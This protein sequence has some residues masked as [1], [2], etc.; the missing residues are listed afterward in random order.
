[1]STFTVDLQGA[2]RAERIEGVRS[3]IGED[4]TGSFGVLPGHA[5]FMTVLEFGL[6]RLRTTDGPWQYLALPGGLL[7]FVDDHMSIVVRRYLKDEDYERISRVLREQMLAEEEN[8]RSVK[9]SLRGMEEELL[10]RMWEMRR[11]R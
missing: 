8:L 2:S 6:A 9:E 10:R 1:M 3:F 4:A 5:R 11:R 7:Y